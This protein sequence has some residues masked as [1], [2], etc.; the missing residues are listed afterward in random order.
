MPHMNDK[1]LYIGTTTGEVLA[2]SR[3]TGEIIWNLPLPTTAL[4]PCQI[5]SSPALINGRLYLGTTNNQF[6]CIGQ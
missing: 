2:L 1:R 6:V 4:E 3:T 5:L